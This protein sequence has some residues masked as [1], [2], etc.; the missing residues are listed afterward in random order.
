MSTAISRRTSRM[1]R[2]G[3]AA[4]VGTASTSASFDAPGW[5]GWSG[6]AVRKSLARTGGPPSPRERSNQHDGPPANPRTRLWAVR[7]DRVD[8]SSWACSGGAGEVQG[9]CRGDARGGAGGGAGEV[10][11]EVQGR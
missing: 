1:A 5:S 2:E 8:R 10:Q 7:A 6:S 11:G 4:P 9:R 3:G